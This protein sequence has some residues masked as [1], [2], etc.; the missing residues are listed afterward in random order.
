MYLVRTLFA[1]PFPSFR[2]FLFGC[3]IVALGW[4]SV[5]HA[6]GASLKISP[7]AGVYEV[8]GVVDVSFIVDTGGESINA[9]QADVLFPADKLQVVNPVASTSFISLWVTSP[10]YSNTDGTIHFQG[11]LPSPGIK[12]SG[13]VISTVTF[14]VKSSGRAVIR[15]A[16]TSK[17]LRND[18]QGTNILTSSSTAEYT[19][20]VPPP[21][22]PVTTSP[23]HPD[24]NQWYNNPQVQFTWEPTDGATGYSFSF[25][26]SSKSTP[27]DTVDTTTTAAT[28]KADTDGVWYFHVRARTDTWGGVTSVPVQIDTTPPASFS[29]KFDS[30]TVTIDDTPTLRFLTTDAASGIDHYEM[31]QVTKSSTNTQE[32][33][34][35]VE[36]TSPA[37]I[38]RLPEGEYEYIVRAFD[39]AGNVTEGSARLTVIAKGLP[40]YARVPLL[41][42]PAVANGVLIGLGVLLLATTGTLVVRRFRFRAAFQHDLLA[43]E[44]DAQKKA[45]ALQ[46][47]LDDL[48]KAQEIMQHDLG[49]VPPAAPPVAPPPTPPIQPPQPLPPV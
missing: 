47:E 8:G 18:G 21:A 31:K 46:H 37:A 43:L 33:T 28:V 4:P 30:S 23:T 11:G 2:L 27:D 29:P 44:H 48:R 25:D 45:A 17:V 40:F 3:F 9:V 22:G 42:N 1:S 14:R 20:K 35:F 49:P 19:L 16:P 38:A 24:T 36:A 7:A 10:T 6:E 32:N 15:F 34:L 13:G 5:M 12:T 41:R 26:Q 39:R